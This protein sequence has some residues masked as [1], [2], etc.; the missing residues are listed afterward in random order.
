MAA[1]VIDCSPGNIDWLLVR[2]AGEPLRTGLRGHGFKLL[3]SRRPVHVTRDSQ[4]FFLALFNQVLGQL[5]SRGGFTRALQT[6]H[7]DHGGWLRRQVNV[8]DA[9]AHGRGQFF[10]DDADQYLAGLQGA[11]HIGAQCFFL[12]AGNKVPYHRQGHIG[13]QQSH[14]HFTQ[15]VLHIGFGDAGL[16]AHFLDE[17]GEFVGKG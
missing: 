12:D 8:A 5:G 3:D 16:A 4:H 11:H 10:A 14:A 1:C 6:S 9:L 13:L 2:R 17:A 7:Q 15:H